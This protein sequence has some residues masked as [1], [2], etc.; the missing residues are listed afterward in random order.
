MG[1]YQIPYQPSGDKTSEVSKA[2]HVA[3]VKTMEFSVT[4]PSEG[5]SGRPDSPSVALLT[6]VS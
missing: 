6:M 2:V 4:H 5:F 1:F 3:T